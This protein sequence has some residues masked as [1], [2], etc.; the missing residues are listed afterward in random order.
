LAGVGCA[1]LVLVALA[2]GGTAAVKTTTVPA[3]GTGFDNAIKVGSIGEERDIMNRTPCGSGGYFC[4]VHLRIE[5][6]DSRYY[7]IV[8]AECA[9]GNEQRQFYFDVTSCFPCKD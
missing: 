3:G 7:D 6:K 8:E 1:G 9:S 2:C 5:E 4:T